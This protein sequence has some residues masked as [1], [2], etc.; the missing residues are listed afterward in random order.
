MDRALDQ[1]QHAYETARAGVPAAILRMEEA[2]GVAYLH[3]AGMDNGAHRAPGEI[4]C[5]RSQPGRSYAKTGDSNE[6]SSTF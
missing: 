2:L 1:Y 6:P 3:K 4:A 5:F